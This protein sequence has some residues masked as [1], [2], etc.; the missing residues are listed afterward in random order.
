MNIN[1]HAEAMSTVSDAVD[2][3]RRAAADAKMALEQYDN[4]NVTEL[5][6]LIDAK[7]KQLHS[8]EQALEQHKVAKPKARS[9]N[10]NWA[11]ASAAGAAGGAALGAV[12]GNANQL[13]KLGAIAGAAV[14]SALTALVNRELNLEK[15]RSEKDAREKLAEAWRI[16]LAELEG[17]CEKL[18]AELAD[19]KKI[20]D[21]HSALDRTSLLADFDER[22]G[23]LE[24]LTAQQAQLEPLYQA[25]QEKIAP[26]VISLEGIDARLA[27]CVQRIS[28]F[29]NLQSQLDSA[30]SKYEKRVVH[31][32]C[33]RISSA[34]GD[35]SANPG[36]VLTRLKKE[37]SALQ[38][39]RTKI[40]KEARKAVRVHELIQR[41]KR[42]VIDGNNMCHAQFAKD[43]SSDFIGLAAVSAACRALIERQYEVRV[44]FDSSIS[45]IKGSPKGN[46]LT[47]WLRN[48]LGASVGVHV[49]SDRDAADLTVLN[50]ASDPQTVAVSNDKFTEYRV[51]KGKH[52]ALAD[53]R[54][55]DHQIT[56]SGR[57][58][59]PLLEL[60]TDWN[61]LLPATASAA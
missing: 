19:L 24:N 1:P 23:T 9:K 59:I 5:N 33:E 8:A 56:E 28:D 61:G 4:Y 3:A 36:F 12:F 26:Y 54:V 38:R 46:A 10:K 22:S 18:R 45:K 44:V 15:E 55:V 43:G 58:F 29:E 32:E 49:M 31:E 52:R 48:Q 41:T 40:E 11:I 42:I 6:G 17:A 14:G 39:D 7:Q 34:I 30:A 21:G 13:R 50:E 47:P 37:Q 51:R 57:L 16:G 2:A 53:N 20:L 27:I 25:I 35:F 60:E